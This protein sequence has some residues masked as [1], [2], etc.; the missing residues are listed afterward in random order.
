MLR[1]YL[2]PPCILFCI[3]WIGSQFLYILNLNILS[4]FG[5]GF[6]LLVSVK[7]DGCS[8][9]I[10]NTSDGFVKAG[11]NSGKY[12]QTLAR[13]L[14][15]AGGGRPQFAQGAGKTLEN[16]ENLLEEIEKEFLG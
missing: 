2:Q 14:N 5:E 13:S 9:I 8:T 4:R 1:F 7:A 10:S 15:G 12:V 3:F 6:I 11:V 16:L